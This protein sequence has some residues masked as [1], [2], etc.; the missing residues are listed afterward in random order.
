MFAKVGANLLPSQM[1]INWI[2]SDNNRQ[3]EATLHSDAIEKGAQMV[4]VGWSIYLTGGLKAQTKATQLILDQSGEKISVVEALPLAHMEYARVSH[5]VCYSNP[6]N[7]NNSEG[8]LIVSGSWKEEG[9]SAVEYLN[10]ASG[11]EEIW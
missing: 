3:N 7:G 2:T 5:S 11:S 8:K 10:I 1:T 6:S 4:Q 9:L